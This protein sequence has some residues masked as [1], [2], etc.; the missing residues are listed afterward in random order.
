MFDLLHLSEEDLFAEDSNSECEPSS[1]KQFRINVNGKSHFPKRSSSDDELGLVTSNRKPKFSSSKKHKGKTEL[2]IEENPESSSGAKA[3]QANTKEEEKIKEKLNALMQK[4]QEKILDIEKK[5]EVLTSH[6]KFKFSLKLLLVNKFSKISGFFLFVGNQSEYLKILSL[7]DLGSLRQAT[8]HRTRNQDKMAY[9]LDYLSCVNT[10]KDK[11]LIGVDL[12]SVFFALLKFVG[13]PVRII[14]YMTFDKLTFKKRFRINISKSSSIDEEDAKA[15]KTKRFS[16]LVGPSA[17]PKQ[18]NFIKKILNSLEE[19]SAVFEVPDD[20]E[21]NTYNPPEFFSENPGKLLMDLM[22][23]KPF[24]GVYAFR[25]DDKNQ[26]SLRI[27]DLTVLMTD[28]GIW[29]HV[30]IN[31]KNI[32]LKSTFDL[33]TEDNKWL[34]EREKEEAEGI[35]AARIPE[36]VYEFRVNKIYTLKS[37]LNRSEYIPPEI[38]PTQHVFKEE[39]VY[40]KKDVIE[41]Y[42]R[43]HYRLEGRIVR[44][45]ETPMKIIPNFFKQDQ[46]VELFSRSQTENFVLQVVGNKLP[47]NEYG[48]IEVYNGVPEKCVHL[49]QKGVWR[50]CKQLGVQYKTAITGFDRKSF[51]LLPIKSGVVILK[52]DEKKVRQKYTQ[53]Q[54]EIEQKEKKKAYEDSKRLW[55]SLLKTIL[56]KKYM[57]SRSK[58]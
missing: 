36:S 34:F 44:P 43:F 19:H 2:D 56:V 24:F 4:R 28:P 18:S 49:E 8:I 29:S 39:Q 7:F 13:V 51:R 52:K 22:N 15:P 53:I 42:S 58:K 50:A 46:L 35:M 26:E 31:I 33:M 55:K 40:L 47:E 6:E 54:L 37:I 11:S 30:Y 38:Q 45:G 12:V 14:L 25:Q 32:G 41:L 1:Y 27:T 23:N 10:A 21:A 20:E 57:S 48:N 5:I 16:H 17:N 9:I 3:F